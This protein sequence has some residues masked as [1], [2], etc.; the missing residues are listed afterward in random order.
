MNEIV[1]IDCLLFTV[2][3]HDIFFLPNYGFIKTNGN[4]EKFVKSYL[5]KPEVSLSVPLGDENI[6]KIS[7]FLS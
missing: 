6:F 3:G 4:I 1:Q 2:I 7:H 5:D